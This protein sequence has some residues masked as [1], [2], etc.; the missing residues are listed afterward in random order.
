MF[1]CM[2]SL[3]TVNLILSFITAFK[4]PRTKNAGQTLM[5]MSTILG[6]LLIAVSFL[7]FR[8]QAVPSELEGNISQLARTVYGSK[9]LLYL[10][11]VGATMIILV[12]AANTAFAGFPRLSAILAQDGFL[13]RRFAWKGTRLVFTSGIIFLSIVAIALILFFQA[14]VNRLIPLYAVGVFFSFTLS[15]FGMA[16]RW[17]KSGRLSSGESIETYG[18]PLTYDPKWA[19]KTIANGV[20]AAASAAIALIFAITKF[21]S[22]AWVILILTPFLVILSH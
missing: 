19:F 12:M 4:E 22:G 15:Q 10:I 1:I 14:S 8:A 9:N 7:S 16:K 2:S 17:R 3:S 18:N 5:M 11:T 20:G 6:V 21:T 13:L